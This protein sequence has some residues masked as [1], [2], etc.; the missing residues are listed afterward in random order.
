MAGAGVEVG[1]A[2]EA[3][4]GHGCRAVGGGAVAE[5][6]AVVRPPAPCRAVAEERTGVLGAGRDQ[7]HPG[8]SGDDEWDGRRRWSAHAELAAVVRPPAGDRAVVG[9]GAR[10]RSTAGDRHRA[11]EGGHGDRLKG[12]G[13]G[14][15]AHLAVI[16]GAPA[17][18]RPNVIERA[19][20]ALPGGDLRRVHE[21]G[22]DHGHVG[23][24]GCT[25]GRLTPCVRSPTGDATVV[26]PSAAE[27]LTGDDGRDPGRRAAGD[28]RRRQ[29]G[30]H[31]RRREPADVAHAV[32]P[33]SP[34]AAEA[35]WRTLLTVGSVA[36]GRSRANC[37][38]SSSSYPKESSVA[39][40]TVKPW[41]VAVWVH[42]TPL[43]ALVHSMPS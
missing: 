42:V 1:G 17:P 31:H 15:V 29:S 2:R 3:I 32:L 10:V 11:G 16:V 9:Q 25:G 4:H 35:G 36:G 27:L 21:P 30:E 37:R 22:D 39:R 7:G 43:S 8:E 18:D 38:R 33:P 28:E 34:A 20:V 5:L 24:R 40:L 41:P 26:E 6:A 13:R 12:V 14:A 19:R 23:T